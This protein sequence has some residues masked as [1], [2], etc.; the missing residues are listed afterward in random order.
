MLYK[1]EVGEGLLL[2]S[3]EKCTST[4]LIPTMAQ[5]L[6]VHPDA[7]KHDLS[8]LIGITL[9]AMSVDPSLPARTKAIA[10]MAGTTNSCA[11]TSTP[12]QS[13]WSP[14]SKAH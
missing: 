4:I 6:L 5:Q 12:P 1:W 7:N 14:Q 2:L 3:R 13:P 9:G 8:S 10:P 11:S